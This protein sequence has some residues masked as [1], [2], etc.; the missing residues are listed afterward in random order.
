MNYPHG[1]IGSKVTENVELK[2]IKLSRSAWITPNSN[3]TFVVNV[4]RKIS[5]ILTL[6][7]T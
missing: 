3:T 1:I 4:K 2:K 6:G 7:S 5:I